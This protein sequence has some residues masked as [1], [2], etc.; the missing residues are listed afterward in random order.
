MSSGK[1]KMEYLINQ[2]EVNS[3]IA[4]SK[5]VVVVETKED[6]SRWYS[7]YSQEEV[8]VLMEGNYDPS[9]FERRK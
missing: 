9:H 4:A 8:V 5:E 2:D 7:T 6:P 3:L 1:T